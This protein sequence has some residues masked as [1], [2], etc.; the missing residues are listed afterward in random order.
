M[1]R[2]YKPLAIMLIVLVVGYTLWPL[3]LEHAS[4]VKTYL[5][6]YKKFCQANPWVGYAIYA[7]ILSTILLA[8][9]PVATVAMLFAGV[10][11]GFWE[12]ITL[13]TIC[14]LAAA[15]VSLVLVRQLLHEPPRPARRQPYFLR[16]FEHHP[17][18]GLF[19]ARLAPIPDSVVNYTL[20]AAPMRQRD[21]VVVS[22]LG[23]IPF[24]LLCVWMGQQLGT[25]SS[26]VRFLK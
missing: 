19:L 10:V 26:F 6:Q 21:F 16:K 24:T 23:M 7:A 4:V 17:K 11:Y 9:L 3:F 13:V 5:I 25:V 12:A 22:L 20:A 18:V 2:Y 1:R 14:R 8:G 15:T